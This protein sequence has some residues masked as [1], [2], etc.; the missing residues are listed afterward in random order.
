MF[1]DTHTVSPALYCFLADQH[2]GLMCTLFGAA[3]L[4]AGAVGAAAVVEATATVPAGVTVT[5]T[6]VFCRPCT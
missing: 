2:F 4:A 1:L 3:V 5:A 6:A